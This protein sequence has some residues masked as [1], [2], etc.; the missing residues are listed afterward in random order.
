MSEQDSYTKMAVADF[1][2]K[3]VMGVI[4][5]SIAFIAGII[6]LIVILVTGKNGEIIAMP[7]A[8]IVVGALVSVVNTL[9]LLNGKNKK[10]EPT[11]IEK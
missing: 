8:F 6:F 1:T 2:V 7:I 5:G 10:K 11:K 4:F 9:I 3:L